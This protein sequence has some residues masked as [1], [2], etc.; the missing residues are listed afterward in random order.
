MLIPPINKWQSV[1]EGQYYLH[2]LPDGSGWYLLTFH[3]REDKYHLTFLRD[4]VGTRIGAG[5]FP[6]F[7]RAV[8]AA[9][10]YEASGR[11]NQWVSGRARRPA[12]RAVSRYGR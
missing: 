9:R 6:N 11:R 3:P 2:T 7:S 1:G 8:L 5:G 10:Q 12:G 4:G